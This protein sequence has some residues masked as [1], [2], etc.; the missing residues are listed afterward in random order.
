MANEI[1]KTDTA[2]SQ[3]ATWATTE[4]TN[5]FANAGVTF[6]EYNKECAVAAMTSIFQLV[7]TDKTNINDIDKSSIRESV[8]Q[9]ASLRLNANAYPAEC[10]FQIRSVQKGNGWI[11]KVEMGIQGDGFNTLLRTFG[12]GV[13]EVY[14]EWIVHEGDDF[15]YPTHKGI[16]IIEP[17]WTPTGKSN[18]ID[19]VVTIVKLDNDEVQYLIS[20]RESARTN[21]I[22]HI[23]N[24]MM[25]ETFGICENRYKATQDQ[26]KKIAEKKDA[27]F[28]VLKGCETV[29]QILACKEAQPYLSPAWKESPEAMISRKLSNNNAK[30][31]KKNFDVLSKR[32]FTQLDDAVIN[33]QEEIM[34]NENSED[35]EAAIEGTVISEEVVG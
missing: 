32:S 27:I 13:K 11:K 28:E 2:L 29:D 14:P 18:R 26:K 9:A 12:Q 34:E 1:V 8:G 16:K 24:N 23:R 25:N 10:Y 21:L 31:F 19:K 35:F 20:E 3:W 7:S 17:E 33:S 5:S 30:R 15:K 22:A 6:D 4:V